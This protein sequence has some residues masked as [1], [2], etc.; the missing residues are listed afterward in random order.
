M[1]GFAHAQPTLR[2]RGLRLTVG[3][4]LNPIVAFGAFARDEPVGYVCRHEGRI[5]PARIAVASAAWQLEPDHVASRH[6]LA[7]LRPDAPAG[8]KRDTAGRAG[9]PAAAPARRVPDPLE[10]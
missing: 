6:G 1:V 10:I 2:A 4:E 7:S 5:A 8:K 9:V 3:I